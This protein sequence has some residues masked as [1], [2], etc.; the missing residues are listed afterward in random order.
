MPSIGGPEDLLRILKSLASD[1]ADKTV[2]KEIPMTPEWSAMVAEH[3]RLREEHKA[4][5]AKADN[6]KTLL[7]STIERQTGLFNNEMKYDS[8]RQIIVVWAT[9][10]DKKK[11][12]ASFFKSKTAKKKKAD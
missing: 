12:N 8:D 10:E 2:L 7:W 6:L 4:L 3:D 9:E 5:K 11:M 1:D